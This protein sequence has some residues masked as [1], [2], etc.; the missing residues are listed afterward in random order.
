VF[1]K[2]EE[3]PKVGHSILVIGNLSLKKVPIF[4]KQYPITNKNENYSMGNSERAYSGAAN[5]APDRF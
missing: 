5:V 4:N 2:N 1:I 3:M